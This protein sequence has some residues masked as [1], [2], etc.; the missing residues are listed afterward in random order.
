MYKSEVMKF[1][2]PRSLLAIENLSIYRGVQSG[3]KK[4]EAFELIKS[5]N[6]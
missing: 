3:L 2:H 5:I 1:P 4:A 6:N